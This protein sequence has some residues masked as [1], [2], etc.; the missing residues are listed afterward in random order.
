MH[1]DDSGTSHSSCFWSFCR[2]VEAQRATLVLPDSF[3]GG[4]APRLQTLHLKGIPLPTLREL[5]LS[6]T[7][8]ADLD[9]WNMPYSGCVS[10]E[11]IINC[12][13]AMTRFKS[14]FLRFH[15]PRSRPDNIPLRI[16][17]LSSP[18]ATEVLPIIQF[19][20]IQTP[21]SLRLVQE[22]VEPFIIAQQS[23]N[24]PVVVHYRER[25][26]E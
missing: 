10:A 24:H 26:G 13:A 8:L 6:A 23:P 9:P 1:R 3:F 11:A 15:S 19:F 20:F 18:L 22:A 7:N 12:L 21:K 2:M 17:A 14:F 16:Y 25:G 5:L 4:F